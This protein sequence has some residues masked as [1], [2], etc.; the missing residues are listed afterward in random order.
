M[1]LIHNMFRGFRVY[2]SV[3]QI[4]SDTYNYVELISA[5]CKW[6][7]ITVFTIVLLHSLDLMLKIL[8]VVIAD[9]AA[10][11]Y[12]LIHMRFLYMQFRAVLH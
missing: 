10:S 1:L 11:L 8:F 3:I 4:A 6:F 2:V 7:C 12:R 5:W 9:S